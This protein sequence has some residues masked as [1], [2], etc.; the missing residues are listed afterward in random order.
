[1]SDQA[2]HDTGIL[3]QKTNY[4]TFVHDA[5]IELGTPVLKSPENRGHLA[6]K[7]QKFGDPLSLNLQKFGTPS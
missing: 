2:R 5:M 1:M 4:P 3:V 7:L 6:S